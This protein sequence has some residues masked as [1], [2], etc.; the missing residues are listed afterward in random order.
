[1][2]VRPES[3]IVRL[4]IKMIVLEMLIKNEIKAEH[5]I[6]SWPLMIY[7]AHFLFEEVKIF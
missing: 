1:M 4:G 5:P 3:I 6:F 7:L 2:I